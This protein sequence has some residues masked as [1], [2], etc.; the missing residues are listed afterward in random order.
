MKQLK[1]PNVVQMKEVLASRS[2]IFIVIEYISGG[3]LFEEIVKKGYSIYL[4]IDILKL[5]INCSFPYLFAR[6][7]HFFSPGK[8]GEDEARR[9][10]RQMIDGI[11]YCHSQGVCHRDLKVGIV[12]VWPG[13]STPKTPCGTQN[14]AGKFTFGFGKEPQNIRFWSAWPDQP[15]LCLKASRSH[16]C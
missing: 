3:E 9:Y 6:N 4:T 13:Y 5:L 14:T 15:V 11:C 8:F 16:F 7:P 12:F 10:F 2:K 1:H